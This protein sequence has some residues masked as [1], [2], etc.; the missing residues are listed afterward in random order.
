MRALGAAVIALI[1]LT[2]PAPA[3]HGVQLNLVCLKLEHA[4]TDFRLSLPDAKAVQHLIGYD[5][6]IFMDWY[7]ARPPFTNTVADE[8]I[9]YRRPR[10]NSYVFI[11]SHDGCWGMW[12]QWRARGYLT[13]RQH[14]DG[15]K[16]EES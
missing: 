16:G 13:W 10:T 1:L 8:I 3:H 6:L 14:F 15:L 7:N 2:S 11:L 4:L 9:I 12:F 5:A